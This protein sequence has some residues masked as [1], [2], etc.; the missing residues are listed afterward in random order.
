ML[1]TVYVTVG[2]PSVR[3]SVCP[4]VCRHLPL[5]AA[6]ARAADIHRQL[7]AGA[8]AAAAGSVML[9]AEVRG[10]QHRLVKYAVTANWP[11]MQ[12]H[13]NPLSHVMIEADQY[14]F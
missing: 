6:W 10:C 11:I 4:F 2:C 12:D 14:V 3:P 7:H 13:K 8:R 5:A 1:C 9:R